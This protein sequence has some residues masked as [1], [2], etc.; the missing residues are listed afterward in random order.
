[1]DQ[2]TSTLFP[3][4]DPSRARRLEARLSF[5][6]GEKEVGVEARDCGERGV[7]ARFSSFLR[8]RMPASLGIAS[9]SNER[10]VACDLKH[11]PWSGSNTSNDNNTSSSP[12]IGPAA[13]R[14]R[15]RALK[16]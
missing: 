16:R 4:S 2:S 10:Q 11:E 3:H 15:D 9:L 5:C 8:T 13:L 14:F 6:D 1:M 7:D 12:A